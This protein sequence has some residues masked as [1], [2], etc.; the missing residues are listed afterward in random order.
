MGD[1]KEIGSLIRA[2]DAA[3]PY[4]LSEVVYDWLKAAT[5]AQSCTLFL[6]DY[7]EQSLE[8]VP[9]LGSSAVTGSQLVDTSAA[10]DAYRQQ[11]ALEFRDHGA[12]VVYVPITVRAERLGVLEVGLGEASARIDPVLLEA[13]QVLG[14]VLVAARRYTDRFERIRRRRLLELPAEIQWELLP[15]LAYDCNEYA[16]A[17]SLEP[18]YQIGGDTFDY[19]VSPTSLTV[20]ITDAMGHGLRSAVL[21]SLAI[22]AMRN[23]RRRGDG[24]VEQANEAGQ[25]IHAQF[26]G[27]AFVTANLFRF[28]VPSGHGVVVNAG[29][30]RPILLRRGAVQLIEIAPDLP[31]GIFGDT[32][33]RSHHVSVEPGDRLLLL[34]DGLSDARPVGGAPFGDTRL[35]ELLLA[36]GD[37]Q[38]PEVVRLLTKAAIDHRAGQLQ[39]DATAVC[40]DWR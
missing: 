29:H 30:Q 15:V 27:D 24:V 5:G 34:S 36:S 32:A 10:G 25:H 7:N 23:V 17:G 39:D 33:Y 2:L 1:S 18:A 38:P 28:D 8:S 21:A 6:A 13:A 40:L 3:P 12:L 37:L 20:A 9:G 19:A 14:Y 16:V 35:A 31:L 22:T 11:Q 26:G 4:R